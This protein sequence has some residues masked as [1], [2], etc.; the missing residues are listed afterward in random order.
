[1]F[2]WHRSSLT[3][4]ALAGGLVVRGLGNWRLTRDDSSMTWAPRLSLTIPKEFSSW[5]VS[6]VLPVNK[7]AERNT[8]GEWAQ[9]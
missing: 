3:P 5:I 2:P 9:G 7:L 4:P 6:Y 1:M 8:V